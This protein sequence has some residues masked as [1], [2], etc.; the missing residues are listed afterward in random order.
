[1]TSPDSVALERFMQGQVACRNAHGKAGFM[2][3]Y[4][5]VAADGASFVPFRGFA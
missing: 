3:L 2:A 5:T 4:R 1:M